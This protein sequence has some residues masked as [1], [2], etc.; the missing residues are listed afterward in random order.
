MSL[1]LHYQQ[2]QKK[3]DAYA[4]QCGRNPGEI[5]LI[6][7]SKTQPIERLSQL[8]AAGQRHFA[9]NYIKE[10][11]PKIE[12]LKDYPLTW[13]FIGPIQ[14]NKTRDIAAHFDWVHSLDRE[15]IAQRLHAHRLPT[16]QPLNVC[17]EVNMGDEA[18]KPGV[19]L[20]DLPSLAEKISG[21]SHLK[22]RGLMA[23][24]PLTNSN[25]AQHAYFQQL[26]HA[27][28]ELLALGYHL[29]TLSMGT[30]H[31]YPIAIAEGAT[32]LRIGTALFG[33]RG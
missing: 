10:A 16:Q 27:F 11:L 20:S 33:T 19:S 25:T 21:L 23:L 7:V 31:D 26:H 6:A 14:S 1:P 28:D 29:D 18:T 22:L 3:I 8:V 15:K 17:I 12:A 2:L 32:F 9:E 4:Q 24:P 13:H 30:S 5:E